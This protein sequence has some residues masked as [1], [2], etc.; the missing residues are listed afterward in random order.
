MYRASFDW[1]SLYW[2]GERCTTEKEEWKERIDWNGPAAPASYIALGMGTTK[3]V[4]RRGRKEGIIKESS[5]R[6]EGRRINSVGIKE[7]SQ[8]R[9][10]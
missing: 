1:C 3:G 2:K 8:R 4:R 10:H 7:P 5:R 6:S 9:S